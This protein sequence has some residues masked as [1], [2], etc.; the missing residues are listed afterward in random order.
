MLQSRY[1]HLADIKTKKSSSLVAMTEVLIEKWK[2]EKL[3]NY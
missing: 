1:Q 3:T 2:S